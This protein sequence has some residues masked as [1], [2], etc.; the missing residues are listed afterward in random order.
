MLRASDSASVLHTRHGLSHANTSEDGIDREAFPVTATLGRTANRARNG[1]QEDGDALAL[2]LAAHSKT[3]AVHQDAVPGGRC[4]LAGGEGRVVV[5]S[6]NANGR[7]VHAKTTKAHARNRTDLA[8]TL[9]P[10]PTVFLLALLPLLVSNS[11]SP[12]AE[13]TQHRSSS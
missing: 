10:L 1:A 4:R 13:L 11:T 2:G 8:N 3:A 5:R 6:A 9:L 12:R 7:I